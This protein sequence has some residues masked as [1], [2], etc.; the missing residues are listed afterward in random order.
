MTKRVKRILSA[1]FMALCSAF[2]CVG[3][4]AC[5]HKENTT[6]RVY[7]GIW[8]VDAFGEWTFEQTYYLEDDCLKAGA[9]LFGT[10]NQSASVVCSKR[11]YTFK[12]VYK[13]FYEGSATER[14][15]LIDENGVNLYDLTDYMDWREYKKCY[16][17]QDLYIAL[18]PIVYEYAYF[19]EQDRPI[20]QAD[21]TPLTTQFTCETEVEMP[22]VQIENAGLYDKEDY[23]FKGWTSFDGTVKNCSWVY[24]GSI[25]SKSLYPSFALKEDTPTLIATAEDF[26]KIKDNPSGKYRIVGDFTLTDDNYTPFD[27]SGEIDGREHTITATLKNNKG[28]L[29]VFDNFTGKITNTKFVL[30][31]QSNSATKVS[32]GGVASSFSGTCYKVQVSGSI[33]A[34]YCNLGGF[35]GVMNGGSLINCENF[36]SVTSKNI[37]SGTN[38]G[39]VIGVLYNG[40][41]NKTHNNGAV[42]GYYNC[43]GIIGTMLNAPA[44]ITF[45]ENTG[46]VAGR[47]NVGGIVGY[48]AITAEFRD[49]NAYICTVNELKNS[50][51]ITGKERT[52]GIV[53]YIYQNQTDSGVQEKTHTLICAKWI[54][55]GS[56]T[57]ET[58]VGGAI[59][60]V[61][62]YMKD[63]DGWANPNGA[64]KMTEVI[65]TGNITGVSCVGGLLGYGRTD[66]SSSVIISSSSSGKITAEH[67]VGGVCGKV[68][69]I[70]LHTCT[71][72][73]TQIVAT[74]YAIED[75]VYYARV[76]GFAG[77][78]YAI[79]E[80]DNQVDILY[81]SLG[82]YIGGVAG[83]VTSS[84]VDSS[85][86]GNITATKAKHVGGVIGCISVAKDYTSY[87]LQNFGVVRG[88][89]NVGGLVGSFYNTFKYD[90]IKTASWTVTMRNYIN[91]GEV[92]CEL[93]G[94]TNPETEVGATGGCVGYIFGMIERTYGSSA[95]INFTLANFENY[96]NVTTNTTK[97]VGGLIG[98]ASTDSDYADA[99]LH[100]RVCSGL[101]NGEQVD[102]SKLIGYAIKFEIVAL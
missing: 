47:Y 58:E 40:L 65:N 94:A 13:E 16:Q 26:L 32:V 17:V 69:N 19:W 62:M 64:I 2:V 39:G 70:A 43:G 25:G 38:C 60:A 30:D 66:S 91:K 99:K 12:G 75:G 82:C 78:A 6:P 74:G 41:L 102:N 48:L 46:D 56:V 49:N 51:D 21:G 84:I 36:A 3:F 44:E 9:S 71:N 8:Q 96:A 22:K 87:N 11:G 98:I 93:D 53:G 86:A 67:T 15:L 20:L 31:M 79:T 68:E 23:Y 4:F 73:G 76:G 77:Y 101:L 35:F 55:E 95:Y 59:G 14:K 24:H 5:K 72:T 1:V 18:E 54:N 83:F 90:S 89:S 97:S 100:N 57:A 37:E 50:G 61:S 34:D 85:N 63:D 7:I 10:G 27:F 33:Q 29:G 52:G 45:C 81:E 80:C 92:K 42:S 88:Y 28:N